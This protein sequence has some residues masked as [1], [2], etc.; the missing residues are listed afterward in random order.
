MKIIVTGGRK[1]AN[2]TAVHQVL[3]L[4]EPT[5][6]A[7]GDARGADSLADHWGEVH[8]VERVA[9]PAKWYDGGRI[10][11]GAGPKRNKLMLAANLDADLVVAFPGGKGTAHMVKISRAAGLKVLLVP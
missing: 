1:Y 7:H 4:L 10:D 9:Y 8:G 6:I 2:Y 5:L 3:T 11:L